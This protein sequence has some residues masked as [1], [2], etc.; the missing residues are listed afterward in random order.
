MALSDMLNNNDRAQDTW[1]AVVVQDIYLRLNEI[2]RASSGVGNECSFQ[3][4][5]FPPDSLQLY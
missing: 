1:W 4:M 3:V 2:V 5:F